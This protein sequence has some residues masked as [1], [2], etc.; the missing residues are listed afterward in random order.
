VVLRDRSSECEVLDRLLEAVRT[1]ESQALV[2][3]GEPGV[4]KTALLDY[5]VG[6]A[7]RFRVVRAAGVQSEMEL[8]FAG[9]HQ[10]CA[11]MLDRVDGLPN[12]QRSALLTAFGM[13]DGPAPDHFLVGLAVLGLLAEVAEERPLLCVVD[14]AQWLDH[15]SIQTLTFAA[16]RLEAESVAMVFAVR[17]PGE[18]AELAGLPDL[19]VAGLPDGDA[20]AL[21]GS[22]L[23][24]PVDEQVLN[25]I[26]A[27]TRGNPLALLELPRG[28]TLGELAGGLGPIGTAAALPTQIEDSFRRQ[29]APLDA[30]TRR[31]L[32][33]AAAEPLGDPVLVWRAVERLGIGVA[34]AG[35]AIAAGLFEIGPRMRFRHPLVRSAV[36]LAA[37]TEERQAVHR[38]LADA[39]DRDKDP[40]RHAWHAA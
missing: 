5:M 35:P 29:L 26:V 1:G 12:P 25:R 11:P 38:V 7:S 10:L 31:L 13:H 32:L 21:L 6:R 28:L 2:V 20:R 14:D 39:T 4:G 18:V 37:S 3:R 30:G 9:L 23:S 24:R 40:D 15:A 8:A 17:G 33:V 27:E 19:L 36:Y 34:A 16:R 22:A